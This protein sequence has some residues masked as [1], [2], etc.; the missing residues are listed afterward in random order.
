MEQRSNRT[1]GPGERAT[2]SPA[3]RRGRKRDRER[4]IE[5]GVSHGVPL[6]RSQRANFGKPPPSIY[7]D[8]GPNSWGY[9]AQRTLLDDMTQQEKDEV[10]TWDEE[11]VCD[12][13]DGSHDGEVTDEDYVYNTDEAEAVVAAD[14]KEE[15]KDEEEE[16]YTDSDTDDENNNYT[17]EDEDPEDT[18]DTEDPEDTEDT[19]DTEDPEDTED[20]EDPE[21]EDYD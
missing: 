13:W 10:A 8:Y 14:E 16:E 12:E 18:E 17:D 15:E 21:D 4:W 20:T 11:D 19:E 3:G 1:T 7:K 9:D 2:A 5:D 6:R